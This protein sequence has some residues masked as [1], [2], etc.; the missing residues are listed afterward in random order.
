MIKSLG[1][2]IIGSKGSRRNN[3]AI[4]HDNGIENE[5]DNMS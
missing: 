3:V 5:D 1:N 4:G 2:R